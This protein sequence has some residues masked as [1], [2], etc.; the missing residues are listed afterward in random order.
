[1]QHRV[2][3]I[4]LYGGIMVGMRVC[5]PQDQG[6]PQPAPLLKLTASATAATTTVATAAIATCRRGEDQRR[7]S[8]RLLRPA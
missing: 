3:D 8:T 1:M 4:M 2:I 7:G 5:T 6:M